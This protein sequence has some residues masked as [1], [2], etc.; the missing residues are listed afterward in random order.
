MDPLRGSVAE[1]EANETLRKNTLWFKPI[2][3]KKS[4]F[5]SFYIIDYLY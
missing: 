3:L 1:L 2:P 5:I 4:A